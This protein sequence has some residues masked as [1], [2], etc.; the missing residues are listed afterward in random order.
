MKRL[1]STGFL[2]VCVAVLS[3][4]GLN[5]KS[6]LMPVTTFELTQRILQEETVDNDVADRPPE[7]LWKYK[8]WNIECTCCAS[9][10]E[11]SSVTTWQE[12]IWNYDPVPVEE[13]NPNSPE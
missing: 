1:A 7:F 13:H 5:A 6:L 2:I 8:A 9:N 10:D 12:L 3:A 11:I 4:S